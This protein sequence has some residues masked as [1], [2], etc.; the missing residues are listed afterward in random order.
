MK[1]EYL[2]RGESGDYSSHFILASVGSDGWE[3]VGWA[4]NRNGM[5]QFVF[6][7]EMK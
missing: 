5:K 4:Y 3:L 1:W 6:K 7:R 2:E